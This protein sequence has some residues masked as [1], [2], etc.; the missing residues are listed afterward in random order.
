MGHIKFN[1]IVSSRM[2]IDNAYRQLPH[3]TL[4]N[5]NIGGRLHTAVQRG[6]GQGDGTYS[7]VYAD[8]DAKVMANVTTNLGLGQYTYLELKDLTHR[9]LA[10]GAYNLDQQNMNG[11]PFMVDLI[12]SNLIVS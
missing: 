1:V 12:L 3:D 6:V 5:V 4:T 7:Q 2:P 8:N 10:Y 9:Q 11:Q